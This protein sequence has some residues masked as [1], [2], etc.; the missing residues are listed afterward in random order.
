MLWRRILYTQGH[1]KPLGCGI[2]KTI[3][4]GLLLLFRLSVKSDVP[5]YELILD[6]LMT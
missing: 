4:K 1:R 2:Q 5:G 6:S 3:Y